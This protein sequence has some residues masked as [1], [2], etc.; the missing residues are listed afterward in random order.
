MREPEPIFT[1]REDARELLTAK[2]DRER[3]FLA[4]WEAEKHLPASLRRHFTTIDPRVI[5][6]DAEWRLRWIDCAPDGANHQ[7]APMQDKRGVPCGTTWNENVGPGLALREARA[8]RGLNPLSGM[9]YHD[10][11]EF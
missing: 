5:I 8:A 3:Q 9:T 1:G 2:L 6:K 7:C 4:A 10:G 11:K